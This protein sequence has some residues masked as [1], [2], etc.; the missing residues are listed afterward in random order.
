MWRWLM[1]VAEATWLLSGVVLGGESVCVTAVRSEIVSPVTARAGGR[2]ALETSGGT[3]HGT[4][5]V[6]GRHQRGGAVLVTA[7]HCVRDGSRTMVEHKGRWL[8][9]RVMHAEI[10]GAR[11]V[12]I[13]WAR[14]WHPQSYCR[15]ARGAVGSGSRVTVYSR[16]R[17]AGPRNL[18]GRILGTGDLWLLDGTYG[19]DSGAPVAADG[20]GEIVGL[21]WGCPGT[22]RKA[23]RTTGLITPASDIRTCLDGLFTGGQRSGYR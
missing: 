10:E 11:D 7:G 4:A 3:V 23:W 15:L 19:G 16:G 21:L 9:A 12:A 17:P 5:W 2:Y 14:D 6:V 20:R 18:R 8:T 1:L 22:E 13:L